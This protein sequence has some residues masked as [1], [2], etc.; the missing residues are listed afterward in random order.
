MKN[1]KELLAKTDVETIDEKNF[2]WQLFKKL[3]R[4]HEKG[5][6]G[7]TNEEVIKLNVLKGYCWIYGDTEENLRES[8]RNL[9]D[10]KRNLRDPKRT[11]KS[12]YD[13]PKPSFYMPELKKATP[14]S[15]SGR[16]YYYSAVFRNAVVLRLLAKKF[17]E[18]LREKALREHKRNKGN[19]PWKYNRLIDQIESE[20]RSVTANIREGYGRPTSIEYVRFL[21]Y[22]KGSLEEFRG[23]IIDMRDDGQLKSRPG[24]SLIDIGI[25]LRP[26]KDAPPDYDHLRELKRI[27]KDIKGKELTFE[28]FLELVNKTD[29]LLRRTVEGLRKKIIKE[30]DERLRQELDDM[31]ERYW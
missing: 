29:Y 8:K 10:R 22:S 28:M 6:K 16:T 5:E 13:S 7:L 19:P 2:D 26:P 9:R 24:S 23:D 25:S 18:Y 27:I 31:Y 14:R 3:L 30:K 1:L 21:G 12:S 20:T 15:R 17:T 11:P 4:K